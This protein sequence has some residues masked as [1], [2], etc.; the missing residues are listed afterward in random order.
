MDNCMMVSSMGAFRFWRSFA[1]TRP[2]AVRYRNKKAVRAL[3]RAALFAT[4][5]FPVPSLGSTAAPRVGSRA[6]PDT[7]IFDHLVGASE[8][9]RRI[10]Q[11]KP[12]RLL[13]RQLG[14][15]RSLK[16]LSTKPA[17]LR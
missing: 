16:T 13:D 17:A 14:G 9:I 2:E 7:G 15:T 11:L 1:L 4:A 8:E 3:H 6:R 5:S 12:D 10:G